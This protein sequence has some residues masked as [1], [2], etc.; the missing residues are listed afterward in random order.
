MLKKVGIQV[1]SELNIPELVA[2]Q[3]IEDF[4]SGF[5]F[6]LQLPII[7][8]EELE[9]INKKESKSS[10]FGQFFKDYVS[11]TNKGTV[12]GKSN[13]EDFYLNLSKD[14]YRNSIV[15]T[16]REVKS[17]MDFDEQISKDLI[18]SMV[19][20]C[21][22]LFISKEREHFF[23]E[24]IYYGFQNN[25]ILASHILIPQIEN[26]LKSLIE[27]SGRNTTK[28]TEEIQNDNTLGSILSV[29]ENG[30]MLDKICD[31]NL[32]L[33]LNAYL[34]DG[35]SVNFR[36]RICHGLIS[37]LEVDYYGIYLWWLTLKMVMQTDIYFKIP[38]QNTSY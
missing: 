8:T 9:S 28:N 12:S 37:P 10:L 32:L 29:T 36:N 35:N 20:N 14:Y 15:K 21:K 2:S 11:I 30:K 13:E 3:N 1:Q 17:I 23:I 27:L 33:E 31:K 22:S 25:F 24:G 4:K 26:S 6:L 16:I 5:N 18:S 34:V 7:E 19:H 38:K